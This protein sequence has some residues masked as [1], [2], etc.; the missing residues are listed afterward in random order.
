MFAYLFAD[1]CY[2]VY[3][4]LLLVALECRPHLLDARAA[5]DPW[6]FRQR[7]ERE[8]I[9]VFFVGLLTYFVVIP[10]LFAEATY[11][12]S[13][14]S[15]CLWIVLDV[16]VGLRVY[17]A[18]RGSRTRRWRVIYGL[19]L[20]TQVITLV[21]DVVGLLVYLGLEFA[22]WVWVL[23][24]LP[25]LPILVAGRVRNALPQGSPEAVA[26]AAA[27]RRSDFALTRSSS[28]LAFAAL[29]TSLHLCFAFF[30]ILGPEIQRHSSL[31]M[32][33]YV[34]VFAWILGRQRQAEE[35]RNHQLEAARVAD[36][37]RLRQ[38]KQTAEAASRAKSEFLGNMS[39]ELRTPMVGILGYAELLQGRGRQ[40]ADA[41]RR[42][43][44]QR[45][46]RL[47][48]EVPG[49]GNG[50]L[51]RQAVPR[52]RPASRRRAPAA[53]PPTRR[54]VS[55][56]GPLGGNGAGSGRRPRH[57]RPA[58]AAGRVDPQAQSQSFHL[59]SYTPGVVPSGLASKLP[60]IL[61][62]RL[63][64][65]SS[66]IRALHRPMPGGLVIV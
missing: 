9:A 41:G 15:G 7:F 46:G 13:I 34:L 63:L 42:G 40:P 55:P 30:Q 29:L 26:A 47:P 56:L 23:W 51:S 61:P 35:E 24:Y 54:R 18:F 32:L 53:G 22:G 6:R 65:P 62:T 2:V 5:D 33:G 66:K 48:R 36:E 14:P 64:V 19:F 60:P 37:D 10:S 11:T 50:R 1:G 44:R 3:Y 25:T 27:R 12:S 4:I 58:Q 45:D 31:L 49:R 43:H 52:S 17:G 16:F 8:A 20:L 59:P 21:T 39:H 28:V 38:A 57:G